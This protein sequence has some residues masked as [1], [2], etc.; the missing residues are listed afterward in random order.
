MSKEEFRFKQFIILQDRCAMKVG[1][2]GVL[3]G[4]WA[5]VAS[6]RKILDIGT[7]TGLVALMVAQRA[8]SA[9]VT[10]LEISQ[11]A[12]EQARE[13]ADSS[14]FRD[15]IDV[16]CGD[17]RAHVGTYD[18]IVCNPP[19]FTETT[20]SPDGDRAVARSTESLHF[21]ELIKATDGLLTDD[22]SFH[23]ILPT[24]HRNA[25]VS[26]C[27]LYNLF[28]YRECSVKTVERKEPK[29]TLLS[30]THDES[31]LKRPLEEL[32]LNAPDGSRSN[33]YA[34]LTQDFYLW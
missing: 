31:C 9:H 19:F 30:F 32:V 5:D 26:Y 28:L 24:I 20:L 15:R 22:G 23:V 4:A 6:A 21:D 8:S 12:A 29:R 16:I 7:G 10:A 17:V 25:F 11:E 1:T 34:A 18:C 27:L 2:D 3:L 13:N 14:V 33:D